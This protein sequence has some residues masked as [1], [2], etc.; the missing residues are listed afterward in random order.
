[1]FGKGHLLAGTAAATL[2]SKPGPAALPVTSDP[3]VHRIGCTLN[4]R[5]AWAW[6]LPS[7][8]ARTARF[9]NAACAAPG[10]DRVSSSAMPE[11]YD[12]ITPFACR[13]DISI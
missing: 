8:T 1:V 11:A 3:A 2:L 13:S 10:N 12:T 5:A 9:R 7:S 4:S 6:V